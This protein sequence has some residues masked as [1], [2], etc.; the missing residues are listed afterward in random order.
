MSEQHQTVSGTVTHI[1]AHRFVVET[2]KGPV[3]ADLTPYGSEQI[4][5]ELG[6]QVTLEGEMKPSELKVLRL[7]RN[8]RTVQVEHKKKDGHHHPN[9]DPEVAHESA[10]TAGFEPLGEPRRKPKHFEVLGRRNGKL[11]ELHIELDGRV[12]KITP[13][14]DEH[15]WAEALRSI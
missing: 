10:R 9:A 8:G 1:F 3:L 12:R 2:G 13:V 7:T 5:L 6:N 11:S 14:H 4:T 15:K